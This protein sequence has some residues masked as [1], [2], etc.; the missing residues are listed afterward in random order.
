[1]IPHVDEGCDCVHDKDEVAC[2]VRTRCDHLYANAGC[3]ALIKAV[4][5]FM[6][7]MR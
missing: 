3:N 4:I 5:V 2:Y 6:M 7:E 1:M